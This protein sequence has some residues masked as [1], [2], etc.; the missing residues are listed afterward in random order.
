MS[1]GI[2]TPT[3]YWFLSLLSSFPLA[4]EV[5]EATNKHSLGVCGGIPGYALCFTVVKSKCHSGAQ[6][7]ELS[8]STL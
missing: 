8:F 6:L 4:W 5:H 1:L 7:L 3:L 2:G